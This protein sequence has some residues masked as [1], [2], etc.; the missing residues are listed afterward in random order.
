MRL[1]Y[2][3]VLGIALASPVRAQ[4]QVTAA[5]ASARAASA[6]TVWTTRVAAALRE[7]DSSLIAAEPTQYTRRV[8]LGSVVFAATPQRSI[9]VS[10]SAARER[11]SFIRRSPPRTLPIAWTTGGNTRYPPVSA[12]RL[13]TVSNVRGDHDGIGA[14][15][16]PHRQLGQRRVGFP[17]LDRHACGSAADSDARTRGRRGVPDAPLA[18][19]TTAARNLIV[20]QL[21]RVE[22]SAARLGV[23]KRR[24]RRPRRRLDRARWRAHPWVGTSVCGDSDG[25]GRRAQVRGMPAPPILDTVEREMALLKA[26]FQDVQ[27]GPDGEATT[28]VER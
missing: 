5:D 25:P 14:V 24:V 20:D 9:S 19:P 2:A 11:A 18:W 21:R 3:A 23:G 15:R 1:A 12:V 8:V 22:G 7:R 17:N 4:V 27:A 10:A 16:H 26:P 13:V 6:S 28:R